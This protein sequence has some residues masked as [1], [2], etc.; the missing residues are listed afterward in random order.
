VKPGSGRLCRQAGG[1]APGEPARWHVRRPLSTVLGGAI[2]NV[3]RI[4]RPDSGGLRRAH[5]PR[6][7]RGSAL[8]LGLMTLVLAAIGVAV[9]VE[10]YRRAERSAAIQKTV[11]D[12]VTIIGQTNAVF[13]RYRYKNLTQVSALDA[14]ILPE[15]FLQP[16]A[17]G[18][19]KQAV[20]QFGGQVYMSAMGV[21]SPP[22][23]HGVLQYQGVPPDICPSVVT[24]TQHLASGISVNAYT[25]KSQPDT[26]FGLQN[27]SLAC[28]GSAG[29]NIQ[30]VF[31]VERS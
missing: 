29:A 1:D 28:S 26:P 16:A 24:Q 14:G 21:G 12:I 2:T 30:W 5:A 9:G 11:S 15:S 17:S 23:W 3:A 10:Q 19:A 4:V 20:N 25:I 8:V 6:W 31:G 13:G 27:I 18:Q 7:Q 22:A